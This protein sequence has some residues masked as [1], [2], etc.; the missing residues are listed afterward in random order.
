MELV[1]MVALLGG[2]MAIVDRIPT[3]EEK[4]A[5]KKA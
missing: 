3:T 5:K 4:K 1:M 2:V